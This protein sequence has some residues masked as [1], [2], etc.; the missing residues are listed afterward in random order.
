MI[1][2]NDRLAIPESEVEFAASRSSGPGG[3]NV[4]KV[5]TKVTLSF[6]LANSPSLTDDIR[7][8]LLRK[9]ANRVTNEGVLRVTSDQFRSQDRNRQAAMDR[10]VNLLSD[11]LRVPRKRVR[12]K[13]T[14]A[15]RERR[16]EEKHLRSSIKRDRRSRTD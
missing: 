11:A 15:S 8:R 6:D 5:S 16:L 4:N 12:T 7:E 3:Q 2:V 13:P 1:R 9:L 10:L 14:V